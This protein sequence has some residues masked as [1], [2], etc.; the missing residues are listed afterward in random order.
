MLGKQENHRIRSVLS[1]A[2]GFPERS[3][4]PMVGS[5]M[6]GENTDTT[7]GPI[8]DP[9]PAKAQ[10]GRKTPFIAEECYS[11]ASDRINP[12]FHEGRPSSLLNYTPAERLRLAEFSGFIVPEFSRPSFNISL[13][14]G[15][16][17]PSIGSSNR[18][19]SQLRWSRGQLSRSFAF[20]GREAGHSTR[21][22]V[23][24][25]QREC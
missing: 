16:R 17:E 24:C 13:R 5:K 19:A 21:F 25:R 11:L 8:E 9:I 1:N 10:L 23:P 7:W 3:T 4:Q 6:C 18:S 22:A 15:S 20:P 14:D 2:S 12:M